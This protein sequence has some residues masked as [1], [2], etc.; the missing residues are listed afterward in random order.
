MKQLIVGILVTCMLGINFIFAQDDY[1]DD[2]LIQEYQVYIQEKAGPMVESLSV[3]EKLNLLYKIESLITVYPSKDMSEGQKKIIM[4]LLYALKFYVEA[5]F[6]E[7][8]T[9]STGANVSVRIIDDI[10]CAEC[11]TSAIIGQIKS[12]PFLTEAVYTQ[13][14]FSDSWVAEYLQANN[15]TTLPA[16]IFSTNELSDGG[17]VVPYLSVL[18]DGQYTLALGS[19]FDPFEARSERGFLVLE[20]QQVSSVLQ[21]TY[22]K[23][24]TDAEITWIE[25]TDLNCHFC[26]KMEIDGT[27][28]AVIKAYP[29]SVNKTSHHF[30]GVGGQKSQ[31]WAELL[32]CIGKQAG[33]DIYNRVLSQTLTSKDSS[34]TAI[35]NF[36]QA[37]WVDRDSVK[38]CFDAGETKDIIDTRFAV[39]REVFSISG[40]PG[41]VLIN[42]KS[43]EYMIISG[44]VPYESFTQAI[45]ELLIK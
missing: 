25:Y 16:V 27:A 6:E 8:D 24:N 21:G 37:E 29:N 5:E 33:S 19:N 44:A 13:Q 20:K 40:T 38:S 36:A 45:E 7:Q 4:N 22:I 15:I 18:P 23:G 41:N 39:G 14:D 30:I 31:I 1:K 3:K 32:E 28:D 43:G 26:Q 2:L 42:T 9:W 35:L 12:L 17:Q 10:R 34:E 11:Q